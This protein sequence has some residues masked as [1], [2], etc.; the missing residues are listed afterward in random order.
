[1]HVHQHEVVGPTLKVAGMHLVEADLA[2]VCHINLQTHLA[3]QLTGHHL[4]DLVVL[5]QQVVLGAHHDA[6]KE[7][8]K[9]RQQEQH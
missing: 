7:V 5:H 4:V 1:M 6:Y 2:V 8:G 9:Q 3:Q